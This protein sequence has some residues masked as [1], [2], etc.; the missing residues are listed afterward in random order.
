ML[1]TCWCRC[2]RM[3]CKP[4]WR[5]SCRSTAGGAAGKTASRPL[6]QV[7]LQA[8]LVRCNLQEM[9]WSCFPTELIVK[10][11]QHPTEMK[12]ALKRNQIFSNFL[13][14][15]LMSSAIGHL[16]FCLEYK[17]RCLQPKDIHSVFHTTH[18]THGLL[19]T[20]RHTLG[21]S[22]REIYEE[23]L[24]HQFFWHTTLWADH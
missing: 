1:Y 11:K 17:P 5:M 24:L 22:S 20:P 13:G 12:A 4:N 6:L 14:V 3:R 18:T 10:T 7:F 23:H 19:N 2:S 15:G 21:F 8:G 16:S 9:F